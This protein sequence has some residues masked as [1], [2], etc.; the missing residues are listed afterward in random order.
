[1][2]RSTEKLV[3]L[4][5]FYSERGDTLRHILPLIGRNWETALRYAR[6]YNITFQD[7]R[8]RKPKGSQ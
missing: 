1:M 3:E 4:M 6:K 7:H 5:R 8:R 2:R